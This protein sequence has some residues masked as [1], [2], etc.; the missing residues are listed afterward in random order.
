MIQPLFDKNQIFENMAKDIHLEYW[1]VVL[2]AEVLGVDLQEFE[3]E[4]YDYKEK[5]KKC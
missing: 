3:K 1:D 5:Q 2:I 4:F